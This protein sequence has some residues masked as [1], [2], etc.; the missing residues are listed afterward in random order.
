[1][2][3]EE[4]KEDLKR[5]PNEEL[6]EEILFETIDN[7]SAQTT[8]SEERNAEAGNVVKLT[9]AL[10]KLKQTRIE[11]EDRVDRRRIEEEK[12]EANIQIEKEKNPKFWQ[13]CV[14]WTMKYIV[15]G[16]VSAAFFDKFQKRTLTFEETG[17]I[18]SKA[19]KDLRSSWSFWK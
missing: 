3:D 9:D 1:M 2:E 16:F 12:N 11:E 18:R 5:K 8:G 19:S 6:L 14:E 4:R 7:F 17:S 10:T 13:C 15:P